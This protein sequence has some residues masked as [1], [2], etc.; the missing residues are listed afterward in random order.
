MSELFHI[1]RFEY[2]AHPT[3]SNPSFHKLNN[4]FTRK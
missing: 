1:V 3:T 2:T 4:K